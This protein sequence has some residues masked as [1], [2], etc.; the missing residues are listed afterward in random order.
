MW[1]GTEEKILIAEWENCISCLGWCGL[2]WPSLVPNSVP[3]AAVKSWISYFPSLFLCSHL[4]LQGFEVGITFH[5]KVLGV[6][7]RR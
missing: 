3:S 6:Q 7:V 4:S 5:R 2:A 1:S